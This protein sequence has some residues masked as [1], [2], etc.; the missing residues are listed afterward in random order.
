MSHNCQ[1]GSPIWATCEFWAAHTDDFWLWLPS[2]SKENKICVRGCKQDQSFSLVNQLTHSLFEDRRFSNVCCKVK[3][4]F[5]DD[6]FST[7][8]NI[9]GWENRAV[10]ILFFSSCH[11]CCSSELQHEIEIKHLQDV[12]SKW[13]EQPCFILFF[14]Y[15]FYPDA[16]SI[17]IISALLCSPSG[18]DLPNTEAEVGLLNYSNRWCIIWKNFLA[19]S[20]V[21]AVTP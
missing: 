8:K 2:S 9:R 11:Y 3:I 12:S 13:T 20:V 5:L 15:L 18:S 6:S 21:S 19:V 1:S 16:Y 7:L 4:S 17:Q 10:A 14:C